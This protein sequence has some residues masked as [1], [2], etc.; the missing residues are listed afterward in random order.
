MIVLNVT[1]SCRPGMRDEFLQKIREEGIDAVS[2]A[3]EGNRKYD[4]YIPAGG[5]DE[6]LLIEKWS[7]ADAIA[8]H[9]RQPHF[10]RLGELK[11]LYVIETHIERFE[12]P[13]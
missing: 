3:E 2:R 11:P 10:A 8:A 13:D 7:G 1:Y 4:Y 12:C 5:G 6:L 9:G